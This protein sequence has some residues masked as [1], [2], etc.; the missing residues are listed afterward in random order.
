MKAY[1]II[2]RLA[3]L[4]EQAPVEEPQVEP[5]VT[6]DEPATEPA[7]PGPGR[8]PDPYELPPDFEPGGLPHPKAEQDDTAVISAWLEATQQPIQDWEWDGNELRLLLD[9]GSREVYTREQLEEIGVFGGELAFAESEETAAVEPPTDE[10]ED[11]PVAP[12]GEA[13]GVLDQILGR[14]PS[15]SASVGEIEPE[16]IHIEGEEAEKLT[17]AVS[18]VV[19]AILGIV[20]KE[21]G[22]PA[23]I[24]EPNKASNKASDTDKKADKSA[25]K[26]PDK[27]K[28]DK[29]KDP[30]K[31]SDK[32]ADKKDVKKE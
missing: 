13:A 29:E 20:D 5:A 3:A 4:D 6:P 16:V 31:K 8:S 26:K 32:Q 11:E 19:Q 27:S 21:F 12:P 28:A 1:E 14:V 30:D 17:Q 23:E 18:D 2:D 7:E 10:D 9:D 15:G 25:D 22:I 24:A